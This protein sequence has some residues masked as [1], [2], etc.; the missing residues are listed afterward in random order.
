MASGVHRKL[1]AIFKFGTSVLKHW[2][3]VTNIIEP[4]IFVCIVVLKL[5]SR[6]IGELHTR[7]EE[8]P[9]LLEDTTRTQKCPLLTVNSY[10]SSQF[11]MFSSSL[12]WICSYLL[13]W[14]AYYPTSVFRREI[15]IGGSQI[16]LERNVVPIGVLNIENRCRTLEKETETASCLFVADIIN[17]P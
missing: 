4:C 13:I 6:K 10:Y 5:I 1:E 17:N 3:C 7:K 16:D 2:A 9:L 11:G 8:N 14:N 12:P 15:F